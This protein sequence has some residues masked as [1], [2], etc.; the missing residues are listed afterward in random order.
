MLRD[1]YRNQNQS[2][3]PGFYLEFSFE[4]YLEKNN[5]FGVI[6][7]EQDKVD[8]GVDLDLYLEELGTYADLKAHSTDKSDIP[9]N[10]K[11]TVEDVLKTKGQVIYIVCEHDTEKDSDFNYEVTR[12]WNTHKTNR[13]TNQNALSYKNRMKNNV[14]LRR[15]NILSINSDNVRFLKGFTQ[16][17][18]SN[19]KARKVKIMIDGKQLSKFLRLTYELT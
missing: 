4:K 6:H 15:V 17:K 9:G 1:G 13:K 19:G 8:G 11:E 16:G 18:N 14:K 5:L 7:Y 12:Y 10:K 3:W 2:E